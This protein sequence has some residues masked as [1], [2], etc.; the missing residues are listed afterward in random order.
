MQ[1][2]RILPAILIGAGLLLPASG[3]AFAGT[4]YKQHKFKK[5]KA[6]RKFKNKQYKN[7]RFKYPKPGKH[8][9]TRHI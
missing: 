6:F 2:R 7:K 5:Y 8:P 1:L 4:S 3:P 9:N